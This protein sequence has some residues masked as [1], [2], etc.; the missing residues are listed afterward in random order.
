[1]RG[2]PHLHAL[3]WMSDCPRLTSENKDT[4]VDFIDNHVQANLPDEN[5]EPELHKLVK[6]YQ[7]HSHST[8]HQT[9]NCS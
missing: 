8:F 4:Y 3:I 7:K 1:M 6:M 9:N 2:S 5:D